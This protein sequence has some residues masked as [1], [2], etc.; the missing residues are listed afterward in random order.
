VGR[1]PRAGWLIIAV[2][3]V[4]LAGALIYR[5]TRTPAPAPASAQRVVLLVLPFENL[6]GDSKQ[7]YFSDGLTDEMITLLSRQYPKKL[8]VIARTSAMRYRGTQKPLGL[9]ARELGTVNYVLEG[10]VRRSGNHVAINAQLFRAQDKASLWAESYDRDLGDLLAIQH[11]VAERIARSLVLEVV[12]GN[13]SSAASIPAPKAYDAY[14]MGLFEENQRTETSLRKS[15]EYFK[16]A[17]EDDSSYAP[18]YAE[19]ANSYLSSAGWLLLK[20]EEAFPNAKA[21]A[22]RA[23]ELDDRLAEAHAALAEAEHEYEWKWAEAEGEFQRAIQLSPN[24][25][26]VHRG[27]AEFLM[28]SGRTEEAATA[29]ER[30]RELDPLSLII[31]TLVGFADYMDRKYD[32]AIEE[33][34]KVLQLDPRFAPAHYVLGGSFLQMGR[35]D[36]AIS[37][38]QNAKAL[39][40]GSSLTSVALARAYAIAGHRDLAQAALRELQVR[41][42]RHYIS[43]YAFARIY[44]TMGEKTAA[45]KMLHL[46]A[47]QRTVDLMFMKI[48]PAFDNLHE[49]EDFKDLL[50]RIGF[51]ET[52]TTREKGSLSPL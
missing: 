18:A 48:D 28:H 31:N 5:F 49:D 42:S 15:I 13:G 9:I 26:S 20:P 47:R 17:V 32:R 25:V 43:A 36:E 30:A 52:T 22:L 46:A 8:S 3:L 44:A 33:C 41:G 19:L 35:Y 34:T 23:I 6:S 2:A 16:T 39:T 38:M 50:K 40:S 4:A 27:Y 21:A 45:L 11:N 24:S 10:T 12:P 51:P 37:H 1:K 29:M 14:L 7:E